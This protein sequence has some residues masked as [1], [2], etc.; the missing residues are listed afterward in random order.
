LQSIC[1]GFVFDLGFNDCEREVAGVSQEIVDTLRWLAYE[2]FADWN[3]SSIRDRVLLRY[4]M[5]IIIPTCGLQLR[6]DKLSTCVGFGR[7][8]SPSRASMITDDSF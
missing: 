1:G 7:H 8:R 5:G 6:N 3:D 4:R 2:A